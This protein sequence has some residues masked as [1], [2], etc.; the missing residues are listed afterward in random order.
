MSAL[1]TVFEPR[2]NARGLHRIKALHIQPTAARRASEDHD[3]ARTREDVQ[4]A[5]T[6]NGRTDE[7]A[8]AK[9]DED[10][11][12]ISSVVA[13]RAAETDNGSVTAPPIDAHTRGI[14]VEGVEL[15]NDFNAKRSLREGIHTRNARD[16]CG[17]G[18]KRPG[19]GWG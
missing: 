8:N 19:V 12:A 16:S 18:P 11:H 14:D 15:S 7:D 3:E 6:P 2:D 9:D 4:A 1:L 5:N 10:L 13:R 17:L